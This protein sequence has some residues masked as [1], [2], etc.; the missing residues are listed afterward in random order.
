MH[1]EPS[2]A[3]LW[4]RFGYLQT[5]IDRRS[6]ALAIQLAS[7]TPQLIFETDVWG[8]DLVGPRPGGGLV[9]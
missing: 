6:D 4:R 9:E 3:E 8:C 2:N 5:E 7:F 1:D